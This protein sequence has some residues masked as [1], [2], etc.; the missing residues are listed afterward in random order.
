[1]SAKD[2][3]SGISYTTKD[4]REVVFIGKLPVYKYNYYSKT[5]VCKKKFVFYC[6]SE[7]SIYSGGFEEKSDV[8][9]LAFSN[10]DI[11]VLNYAELVSEWNKLSRS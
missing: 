9:F 4:G 6:E 2:L 8:K 10:S 5:R 11:A 1:M 3:K 7:K